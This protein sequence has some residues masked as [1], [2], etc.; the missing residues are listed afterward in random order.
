MRKYPLKYFLDN[1][2]DIKL[3]I[4]NGHSYVSTK[5]DTIQFLDIVWQYLAPRFSY[6]DYLKAFEVQTTID[7]PGNKKRGETL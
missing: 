5:T 1:Q 7:T 6:A 4:E 2:T 3:V